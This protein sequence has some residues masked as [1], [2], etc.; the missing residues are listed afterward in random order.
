MSR[1][2]LILMTI[3]FII[4]ITSPT[5]ANWKGNARA[6]VISGGEDHTL[7][8]RRKNGHGPAETTTITSWGSAVIIRD[9]HSS[10]LMAATW[11]LPI[12]RISMM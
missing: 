5:F 1:T 3:S 6:I 10:R 11:A 7:V 2:K 12:C 8:L 4:F 9:S